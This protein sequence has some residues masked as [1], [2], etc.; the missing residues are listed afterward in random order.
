MLVLVKSDAIYCFRSSNLMI[1]LIMKFI[2]KIDI[3]VPIT[4]I[5]LFLDSRNKMYL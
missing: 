3:S 4:N 5:F 2:Y 1:Y